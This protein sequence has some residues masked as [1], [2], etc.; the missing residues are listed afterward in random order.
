MLNVNSCC[1]TAAAVYRSA[2]P[3]TDL[4]ECRHSA[5][6][7]TTPAASRCTGRGAMFLFVITPSQLP[8]WYLQPDWYVEQ[9]YTL[10]YVMDFNSAK[11]CPKLN[12]KLGHLEIPSQCL[13][14]SS[15]FTHLQ[16]SQYA[17]LS[18]TLFCTPMMS[19]MGALSGQ[20][21]GATLPSAP[22]QM[23]GYW[24]LWVSCLA[25]LHLSCRICLCSQL[26]PIPSM[27]QSP[28]D[29]VV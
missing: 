25:C 15:Y 13:L 29:G 8:V 21:G 4:Q 1:C 6:H 24:I 26:C 16:H 12:W 10:M 9:E 2:A 18:N 5:T 19:G 28:M 11:I 27:L 14:R 7:R 3:V 22:S 17:E 20:L 23:T